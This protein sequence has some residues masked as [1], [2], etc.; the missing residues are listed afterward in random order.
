[1]NTTTLSN[2]WPKSLPVLSE[3][4]ER[5]RKDFMNHW[6]EVLPN[7]YGLIEKFNHQY[8]LRTLAA[9]VRTL[10]I[11]AGLGAHLRFEN[12]EIQREYV[13]LELQPELAK[14][15]DAPI[16][17]SVWL[18]RIARNRLISQMATLIGYWPFTYWSTCPTYRKR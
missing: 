8:P 5:I 9:G 10:E 17:R 13:A 12:L 3:E 14:I 18:S 16:Q 15:I 6:L 4:Q 11:G 7:R 2:S 1:M